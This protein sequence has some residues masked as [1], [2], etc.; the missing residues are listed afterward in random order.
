MRPSL[1]ASS[2]AGPCAGACPGR[3]RSGFSSDAKAAGH[4]FRLAE[5]VSPRGLFASDVAIPADRVPV[6][7]NLLDQGAPLAIYTAAMLGRRD[8]VKRLLAANPGLAR[9]RG[10]HGIPVLPHAAMSGDVELVSAL[11][12]AGATEGASSALVFAVS[13]R[14]PELVAWLLAH[15]APD[16][17]WRNFQGKTALDIARER[18]FAEIE[19]MLR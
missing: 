4:G 16:P 8:E 19:A 12:A 6:F 5:I 10:A 17:A 14:H 9:Q 11:H 18:G 15:A 7:C 3:K 1:G 13:R 2:K